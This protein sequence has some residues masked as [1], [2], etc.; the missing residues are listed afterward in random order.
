MTGTEGGLLRPQRHEVPHAR[1]TSVSKP[2]WEACAAGVLAFQS[3]GTCRAVHF[4]PV[5]LCRDCLGTDLGWET[6]TGLGT[7]RTWT[8]VHRPAS[9]AFEV[10]YAPAVV[11]LD[12]GFEMMTNLIGL[13]PAEIAADMRVEV[14]FHELSPGLRLPYFRPARSR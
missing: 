14:E 4:P 12:E 7:L 10:P 3:C 8:I 1:P 6:S 9:A 13:A 2:F 5:E 11:R